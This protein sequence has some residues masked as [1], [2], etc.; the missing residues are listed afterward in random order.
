[1]LTPQESPSLSKRIIFGAD[2]FGLAPAV[3][4]AVIR[5]HREGLLT[6]T[7]LLV[8][9]PFAADAAR[10]ALEHPG[11]DV[12]CHLALC[13]SRSALDGSDLPRGPVATGLRTFFAGPRGRR[14]MRDELRAQVERLLALG[15]RC[16]HLNGHLN[17]HVHPS[18]LDAALDLAREYRIPAVRLPR[19]PAALTRAAVPEWALGASVEAFIFE[20]LSRRAQPRIAAAGLASCDRCFGVL[21]PG[22]MREAAV[23]ALLERL[24]GGTTEI[25]FHPATGPAPELAGCQPGY[26]HVGELDALCSPRVREALARSGAALTRYSE[27]AAAAGGAA[28]PDSSMS[29]PARSR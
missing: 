18:V 6:S 1:M 2:D 28:G 23:V 16:A 24:P 8:G 11:L 7:S 17:I 21:R 26:D 27:L 15:L 29:P 9:E 19:E 20:R 10:R 3:N 13:Q 25:Y 4:D 22:R 14:R 5:A 12:G